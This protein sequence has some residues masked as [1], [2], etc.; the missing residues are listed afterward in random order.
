MIAWTGTYEL[1]A[2]AAAVAIAVEDHG[3]IATVSLGPG[4]SGATE[5]ALGEHGTRVRF[6]LRDG[7][8]F[9]GAV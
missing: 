5:V 2:S 8:V 6:V 4:H 9:D 1:P 3:R 7:V